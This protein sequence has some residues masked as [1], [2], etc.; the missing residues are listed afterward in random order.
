[1]RPALRRLL[2]YLLRYQRQFLV[3]LSCVAVTTG[4]SLVSP[5][6]LQLAVDDLAAG[7]TRRKLIVYS[8]ALL[9]IALAGATFRFLMRRIIIG[10]S[11]NIEYD[12]RNDFF[13]RLQVFP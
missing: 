4:V 9:G 6:V 1:M 11:R 10:V 13:A 2:P 12:L 5:R 3:G 8:A 7:V